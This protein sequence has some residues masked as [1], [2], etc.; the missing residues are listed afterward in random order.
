M[1]FLTAIFGGTENTLV[2]AGMALGIVLVLI[3]LSVWLLKFFFRA[4]TRLGSG[5]NRRLAVVDS[6]AV[7]PK[8]QLI[9]V[10][11]DDVEHLILTGGP[12]DLVVETGIAAQKPATVGRRRA[13]ASAPPASSEL[14][15]ETPETE[16]APRPTPMPAKPS[17][18]LERLREMARPLAQR[19][20]HS[21]R[22]TGLMRPVSRLE[23]AAIIPINPDNSD[24]R[25]VDSAKTGSN[26]TRGS[27]RLGSGTYLG[28][29]A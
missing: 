14:Q 19:T 21:L 17:E 4:T 1:Q 2:T 16:Q 13:A 8:R 10:R 15:P 29:G 9:I 18:H 23:P 5:P 26:E 20:S 11:R 27:S 24:T 22:H 3:V 12:Q 7:D 25:R 28:D 6:V